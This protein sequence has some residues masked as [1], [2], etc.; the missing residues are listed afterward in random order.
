MGESLT[1]TPRDPTFGDIKR[2]ADEFIEQLDE[3]ER[4][5]EQERRQREQERRQR[6]QERR[7]REEERQRIL[8][9]AL[10]WLMETPTGA[11]VVDFLE[12]S[13]TTI[14]LDHPSAGNACGIR[15]HIRL[16]KNLSPAI[17]GIIL[18]HETMHIVQFGE[19]E[20]L[21]NQPAL[22]QRI[23]SPK[24]F[25]DIYLEL[26]RNEGDADAIMGQIYDERRER[27]LPLTSKAQKEFW[28]N[29][30]LLGRISGH[31]DE[32]A[33]PLNK[34]PIG[35]R[36]WGRIT[37]LTFAIQYQK[38]LRRS[39]PETREFLRQAAN[40]RG[41][42]A[43]QIAWKQFGIEPNFAWGITCKYL[44]QTFDRSRRDTRF[45]LNQQRSV[46]DIDLLKGTLVQINQKKP[47]IQY[48]VQTIDY[49]AA[50]FYEMHRR[51]NPQESIDFS[52]YLKIIK[53]CSPDELIAACKSK[54]DDFARQMFIDHPVEK[55][56]DGHYIPLIS[57]ENYFTPEQVRANER[58][59]TESS[60]K[61][62]NMG[63][64]EL[65]DELDKE[66]N[67]KF[68]IQDTVTSICY[69]LTV[70]NY[71]KRNREFDFSAT[72]HQ[73]EILSSRLEE[74][75]NNTSDLNVYS[76]ESVRAIGREF[77]EAFN[78]NLQKNQIAIAELSGLDF[79]Q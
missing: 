6:E 61:Y 40:K 77:L 57:L 62:E 8:Q 23:H 39:E 47:V 32:I 22:K 30:S 46:S 63:V 55:D 41:Q 7:Q 60:R 17:M 28:N 9:P 50:S 59:L 13:G 56:S 51:L 10:Q 71:I 75:C 14:A 65:T 49:I 45:W 27:N 67:K 1:A 36:L 5:R 43:F 64:D 38:I 78:Q 33:G 70:M 24:R 76:S 34:Q 15:N 53:N 69:N 72:T 66:L 48:H 68:P 58:S 42:Y 12:R 18:A 2:Q 54:A 31:L 25:L 11:A 20:S 35:Q 26:M 29:K 21:K 19:S 74:L 3:Y 4:Q 37:E 16:N 44:S 73:E 52:D 79:Y